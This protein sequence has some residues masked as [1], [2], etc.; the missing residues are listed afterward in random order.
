MSNIYDKVI[1]DWAR[2]WRADNIDDAT[3]KLINLVKIDLYFGPAMTSDCEAPAT[4]EYG[5]ENEW[6]GYSGF[7]TACEHIQAALTDLPRVLYLDTDLDEWSE[8]EP[9]EFEDCPDCSGTGEEQDPQE[10]LS[11]NNE[12]LE[13]DNCDGSGKVAAFLENWYKVEYKELKQAIL[14]KELAEYV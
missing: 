14:G 11:F 3:N 13:C 6:A 8:K 9:N 7:A 4:D 12:E 2:A 1:K 5:N 10:R